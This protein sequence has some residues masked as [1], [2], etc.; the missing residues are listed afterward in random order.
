MPAFIA[1]LIGGLVSASASIAGRVLIALGVGFVSYTGLSAAI[2]GVSTQV[3]AALDA[4]PA[5]AVQVLSALQFDTCLKILISSY[6]AR[7]VLMGLT[8]GAVTKM[9]FKQS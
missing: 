2:S 3:F 5:I 7:L 9:V 1:A 8:S 4:V 6:T